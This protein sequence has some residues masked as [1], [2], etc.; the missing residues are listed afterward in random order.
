MMADELPQ[1]PDLVR[2]YKIA[3]NS[4]TTKGREK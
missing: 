2:N 3:K 1:F 4:T